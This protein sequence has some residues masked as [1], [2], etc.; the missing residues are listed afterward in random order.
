MF[1]GFSN[2]DWD[3][4]KVLQSGNK[5]T[6]LFYKKQDGTFKKLQCIANGEIQGH[7]KKKFAIFGANGYKEAIILRD[8]ANQIDNNT[9]HSLECFEP[10]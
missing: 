4:S 7:K 10:D 6:F 3:S 8:N 9:C 5:G 2:L 1:G